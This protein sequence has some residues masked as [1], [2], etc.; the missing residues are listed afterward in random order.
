MK[1]IVGLGNPGS[2]YAKTRHNIGFMVVDRIATRY[3]FTGLRHRFH[4]GVLDGLIAE[5]PCLLMQ[6]TTYMNRSGTAVAEALAFYKLD[7]ADL[8][9]IVDDI[10]LA[11]GRIRMRPA[12]SAGGHNGLLDIET[13]LRTDSYPRLRVGIDS[14][15]S[16]AGEMRPQ[17]TQHDYVLGRFT[18]SQ[19]EA[20]QPA[21]E[22]ACDAVECWLTDGIDKA[23][24][25]HNAP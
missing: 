15:A 13:K 21:V 4:A 5:V 10:A 3:G 17:I 19:F 11:Y 23:M 12:G 2:E 20:L 1:L 6:P 24:S 18:P 9:V 14:P 16:V 8:V 7:L 25:L 22:R